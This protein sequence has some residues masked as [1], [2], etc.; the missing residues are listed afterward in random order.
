M[1]GGADVLPSFTSY[2]GSR[3]ALCKFV[4]MD[5]GSVASAKAVGTVLV[6]SVAM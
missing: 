6:Q 1:G 4:D 3:P 2:F 5:K